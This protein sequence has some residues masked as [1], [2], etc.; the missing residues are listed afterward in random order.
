MIRWIDS[1]DGWDGGLPA[2]LVAV[3]TTAE[4]RAHLLRALAA[5]AL[6]IDAEAVVIERAE[7]QA[8]RLVTP[9]RTGLILSVASRA[10]FAAF[11]IARAPAGIDVEVADPAGEIPWNV[12]HGREAAFLKML[13]VEARAGAFARLWSLK[14]AYLKALGV[15]FKREPSSF[16][17]RF[18]GADRAAIDDPLAWAEV[19]DAVTTRRSA[20][21]LSAAVSVVLVKEWPGPTEPGKR[22]R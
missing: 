16:A 22:S 11:A 7:G 17:V 13:A 14:E 15:G 21:G 1:L 12:L 5:R 20:N 4:Q 9:P 18:A 2:A 8:P 19:L 10:D 3:G 6:G